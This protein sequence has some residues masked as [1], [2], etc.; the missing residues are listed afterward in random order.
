MKHIY[1]FLFLSVLLCCPSSCAEHNETRSCTNFTHPVN[2]E[3][4]RSVSIY[5]YFSGVSIIPM[6][7][8][9]ES[10]ME[11]P[12]VKMLIDNGDFYFS[13]KKGN[14]IWHFDSCGNFVRKINHYGAGSQEYSELT[15]FRFNRFTGDLE[16]LC[17]WGYINVY[18]H[19]GTV[20]KKRIS[21]NKK[22]I[23]VCHYFVELSSGKYLLFSESRKKNKML[24][25]D[26][27]KDKLIAEDYDLP[28]FLFFNTPYHH[29]YTPFYVFNDT[30]HFVQ[31]GDG[32]VFVADTIGGLKQKYNF[33]FGEYNFDLSTL[34]EEPIEFYIQHSHSIGAKYANRFLA[35]GENSKYYLSRFRFQKGLQHLLLGKQENKAIA[36]G[37]T[38]EKCLFMPV[39][40]DEEFLYFFASPQE[41]QIA[42]NP[43]ILS[44]EDLKRFNAVK[45]EDNLVVIRCKFK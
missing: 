1:Q 22:Y 23:N 32:K 19:S 17:A 37:R 8:T 7:T 24:W 35:Y 10:V 12:A 4:K 11:Y 41:L 30:V 13:T 29:S 26:V 6:E 34:K 33:D 5:D 27:A 42:I 45:P 2:L 31:A 14:A 36:F 18:D 40:M 39:Y 16:I 25:Y 21:F 20:F 9:N 3:E 38:K 43:D 15:D 44:K 28:E